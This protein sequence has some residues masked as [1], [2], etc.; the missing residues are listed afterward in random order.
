MVKS[1]GLEDAESQVTDLD[2]ETAFFLRHL[3]QSNLNQVPGLTDEYRFI[4]ANLKIPQKKDW[5]LKNSSI[6][7][8]KKQEKRKKKKK[9]TSFYSITYR[10]EEEKMIGF[11]F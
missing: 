2:W 1:K 8:H 5:I 9:K 4:I 7:I 10:Y 6:R 11:I 3:P